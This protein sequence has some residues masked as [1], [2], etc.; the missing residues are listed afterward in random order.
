MSSAI[1]FKKLN[2]Y[3]ISFSEFPGMERVS[4]SKGEGPWYKGSHLIVPGKRN[5][6]GKPGRGRRR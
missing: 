3:G 1:H 6:A 5:P 4:L 2:C